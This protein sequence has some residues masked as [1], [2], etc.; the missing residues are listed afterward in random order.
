MLIILV[1]G[2]LIIL[3]KGMLIIL[4]KGMLIILVKGM[5]IIIL[6]G[7]SLFFKR[8]AHYSWNGMLIIIKT[9]KFGPTTVHSYSLETQHSL[10]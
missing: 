7:C 3:V 2:M 6:N 4:V 5:L 8:D 9:T 1:K 10:N